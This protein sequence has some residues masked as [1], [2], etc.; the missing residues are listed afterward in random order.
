MTGPLVLL[1]AASLYFRAYFALPDSIKAPD[2]TSVNAVRGFTDMVAKLI[3]DRRPGR[4]VACLDADWRPDFRVA[5]IPSY[6]AHRLADEEANAEEVPDTLTPQVPVILELL[7]AFG[8]ATAEAEGYEA[9]DVIGTLAAR[10]D[11]DPVVVVTG[12]RDLFQLVREEPT[13]GRVLYAGRGL[14]K[15]EVY[16]PTELAERYGLPRERAGAAYAEMAVLRGD[17][18]DGLPGVAGIGEKTAARLITEFGSLAS[19]LAAAD[20]ETDRRLRPAVRAKL[21]AAK[22]Y[23]AAAP[24]VVNVVTDS[25]VHL[26]RPDTLPHEPKDPEHV[27]ELRARWGL[28]GPVDRLLTALRGRPWSP[29]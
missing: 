26:D 15:A 24:G 25:P 12:D 28:G 16:G 2:G 1:D 8:I 21:L 5:A 27:A 13:P 14:S 23:L 6:K 17:P 9:D 20:D 19:L 10:E 7:A 18:S 11:T 29:E 22:D 4:L 3:T